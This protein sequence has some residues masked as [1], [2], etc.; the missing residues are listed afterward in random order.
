MYNKRKKEEKNV[1]IIAAIIL[2]EKNRMKQKKNLFF[3]IVEPSDYFKLGG[4]SRGQVI[5]QISISS[6]TRSS[7]QDSLKNQKF[8][9]TIFWS[10][11]P[12]IFLNFTVYFE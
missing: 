9:S 11:N 1:G 3:R 2:L 10:F 7:D 6:F 5:F 8:S 12:G 4:P